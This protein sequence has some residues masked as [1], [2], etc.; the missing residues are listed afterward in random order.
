MIT[1][2][3]AA[4]AACLLMLGGPPLM[5][6]SPSPPGDDGKNTVWVVNRDANNVTVFDAVSGDIRRTFNALRG[7]HD[8]VIS[9]SAGKAYVTNEQ[10]HS[11]SVYATEAQARNQA[12]A[13]PWLGK[14]IAEIVVTGPRSPK[15]ARIEDLG[16]HEIHV[17]RS[18]SYYSS[19]EKL[20]QSL[21]AAGKPE[22]RIVTVPEALEDEDLMDM[23]G[24]GMIPLTV[25]DEWKA[26][27]W[28]SIHKRL[29][30]RPELALTDGES[31]GWALRPG[32]PKLLAL[33]NEFIARHPGSR[34]QR[35]KAYPQYLSR[36]KNAT[37]D[38]DWKRFERTAV[39][40]RK[41]APRY[42]LDYLM[43]AALGYQESRLDQ[44]ARSSVGAVGIMQLLPETG[45]S[46]KVGDIT[47]AEPNVHA[48]IKYLRQ[49][50][51]RYITGENVDDQNRT[52][53]ALA[54]YNAGPGRIEKLRAEAPKLGYDPDIWF[55]NMELVVAR[56]IGQ[57]PVIYV[58]NIYKYYVAYKLQVETLE[59][60]RAAGA[61][62]APPKKSAGA[63]RKKN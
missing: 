23:V 4:V 1:R 34:E 17:R 30:P 11:I 40:F 43:T 6:R 58:R 44:G 49:L 33:V 61:A 56:R 57:E 35:M 9:R 10:D 55:N 39:L 41:Y 16:G 19:L 18:S 3:F 8:I 32:A 21:R 12:T 25:V 38:E 54:S 5:G 13:K 42:K 50:H 63:P 51:D 7:A 60:R 45:A 26:K 24:A 52:L 15:L 20:N 46:M 59:A 28:A 27:A 31:I 47:Q 2:T 36:L 14:Y 62:H 53:L 37:A 22:T 29:R 48:G